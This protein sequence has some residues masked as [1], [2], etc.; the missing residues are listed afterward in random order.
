M[1]NSTELN[2]IIESGKRLIEP[3]TQT[4]EDGI[5]ADDSTVKRGPEH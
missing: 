2:E 4:H 1:I 3:S 5:P